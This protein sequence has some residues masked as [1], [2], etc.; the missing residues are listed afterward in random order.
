MKH[1]FHRGCGYDVEI[2]SW[3]GVWYVRPASALSEHSQGQE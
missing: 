2:Q 3:K 1:P